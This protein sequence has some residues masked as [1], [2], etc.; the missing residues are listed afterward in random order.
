[1]VATDDTVRPLVTFNTYGDVGD[2]KLV[3]VYINGYNIWCFKDTHGNALIVHKTD[4]KF[5]VWEKCNG[6][7][8]T[9]CDYNCGTH[10]VGSAIRKVCA[11]LGITSVEECLATVA[12]IVDHV[13]DD[14]MQQELSKRILDNFY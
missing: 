4:T 8:L 2:E 1:M 3:V 7:T 14:D 13:I 10:T 11:K 9:H 6:M 5:N 12:S